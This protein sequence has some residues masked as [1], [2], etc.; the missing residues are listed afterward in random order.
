MKGQLPS[1]AEEGWT[2]HQEN[3]AKLPLKGA[4]GVVLVK[5]ICSVVDQHH[6]VCA[7]KVA[8]RL[9]FDRAATPPL[10]RLR[11][12]ALA[13]RGL[14]RGAGDF[15]NELR[16]QDSRRQLGTSQPALSPRNAR[17]LDA[18]ARP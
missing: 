9:F 2:R 15:V 17:G 3:I 18:I 16:T 10:L 12:I 11:A 14:R 6:P 8:S 13:L 4:D 7:D 5:Q 1:S